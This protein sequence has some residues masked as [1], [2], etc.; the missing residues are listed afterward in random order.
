VVRLNDTIQYYVE[1]IELM[2]SYGIESLDDLDSLEVDW[3]RCYSSRMHGWVPELYEYGIRLRSMVSKYSDGSASA[4]LFFLS[5][6]GVSSKADTNNIIS[7]CAKYACLFPRRVI[8]L[9]DRFCYWP[10]SGKV[11]TVPYSF[12]AQVIILKPLLLAGLAVLSPRRVVRDFMGRT[13]QI[14]A[15]YRYMQDS[16]AVEVSAINPSADGS[17]CGMARLH[18]YSSSFAITTPYLHGV[19][20]DRYVRLVQE[21]EDSFYLYDRAVARLLKQRDN[22]VE[23]IPIAIEDLS[24]ATTRLRLLY[25]EQRRTL[26]FEGVTSAIGSFVTLGTS[27]APSEFRNL[28]AGVG[29]A[30]AIQSLTW[31]RNRASSKKNLRS[32]EFW[33]LW[34]S[35]TSRL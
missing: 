15:W 16:A 7:E 31:L 9:S 2:K 12:L 14:W 18:E 22:A 27:L 6:S 10:D 34:R 35:S 13:Q 11:Y 8:F 32:E 26:D 30:T 21:E 4:S 20:L 5:I 17:S 33:F 28:A 24:A 25:S 23:S 29:G 1:L 19:S 3:S